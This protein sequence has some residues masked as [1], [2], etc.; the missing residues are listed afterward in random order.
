MNTYN[1]TTTA[2]AAKREALAAEQARV[3]Q[4]KRDRFDAAKDIM[5]G[6][7]AAGWESKD[8]PEYMAV[9]YADALLGELSK[10]PTG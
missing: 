10:C 3:A 8:R 7:V 5:A 6:L 9:Y 4:H 1:D 2:D